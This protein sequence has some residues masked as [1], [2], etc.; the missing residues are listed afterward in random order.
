MAGKKQRAGFMTLAPFKSCKRSLCIGLG[1]W[2]P[3]QLW[4]MCGGTCL[5]KICRSIHVLMDWSSA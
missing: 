5:C 1:G 2:L 3:F 4:V